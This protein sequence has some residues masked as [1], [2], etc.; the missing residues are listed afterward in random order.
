M[1]NQSP[2]NPYIAGAPIQGETMFFGRDNIFGTIRARLVG[3]HQD[4]VVVIFGQRRT[5]KTSVL[6]QMGRRLNADRERYV[7][8]LVDLQGLKVDGMDNLLWGLTRTIQRALRR[9][10]QLRMSIPD[11][12]AFQDDARGA[13]RDVFLPSLCE[14]IGERRLLLMFD[15]TVRLEE[16][17]SAGRLERDVFDYLRSLM[18]HERDLSFIFS[19]GSK[20]EHMQQEYALLFNV[21][22]NL[23]ISFLDEDA[24]RALVTEPVAGL[25]TFDDSAVEHLLT[26]TSRHPYFTQLLCHA[27]FTHWEQEGWSRVT[28]NEVDAVLDEAGSLA[29]A[30]LQYVWNE[31][32]RAEK[33]VLAALAEMEPGEMDAAALG[34][35]LRRAGV[36]LG[37]AEVA[38]ALNSLARREVIISPAHPRFSVEL[39]RRWL[40]REKPLAWVQEE[41]RGLAPELAYRGMADYVAQMARRLWDRAE[42]ALGRT[43]LRALAA[44]VIWG[45]AALIHFLKPI[46][47]PVI[48]TRLRFADGMPMVL[49]PEGLFLMGSDPDRDSISRDWDHERPQHEVALSGFWIDQ[50]EVMNEQYEK[51]VQAGECT[52]SN[53]AH[54]LEFNGADYPVVGVDWENARA[55]CLWVGG[56]LPTEAQWEKA[57][58]GADGRIYPWGDEF[59]GAKVNSCDVN[60]P[61]TYRN[62]SYDDAYRRTAPADSF[63]EGSVHGTTSG[64]PS[65]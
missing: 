43:G 50:I 21:A 32:N 9:D 16:A 44:L 63:R 37:R 42:R 5:G 28:S 35:R 11:H 3:Q 25:Y 27:L 36:R 31:A 6:Y 2:T 51:C 45:I 60:C 12:A 41:L 30:N 61:F 62:Q 13:F 48:D 47:V 46:D 1:N 8:V 22:L 58:R 26:L 55:Y 33:F 53:F 65:S 57:A 49:V 18:Q 54:Y 39:I 23:T 52:P 4:N 24:A 40:A 14:A 34:R 15:E 10:Y 20:L 56:D 19:L 64:P 17:V 29:V 59:D 38:R 7:A